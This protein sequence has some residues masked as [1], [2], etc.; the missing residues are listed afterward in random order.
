[1]PQYVCDLSRHILSSTDELSRQQDLL[2]GSEVCVCHAASLKP[3]AYPVWAV[4]EGMSDLRTEGLAEE[5]QAAQNSGEIKGSPW[6][7][8]WQLYA[9]ALLVNLLEVPEEVEVCV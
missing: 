9:V 4:A 8:W 3:P 6:G 2:L 1:M 7:W 5:V